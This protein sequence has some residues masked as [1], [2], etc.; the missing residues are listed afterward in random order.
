VNLTDKE[1]IQRIKTD[2]QTSFES[3]YGY[4]FAKLSYFSNQY[5][6]DREAADSLVQDVFA[7]LWE[8]RKKL[9]DDT[10]I[11]AWLFTVTK[12]K[13]LK[14]IS[15]EKSKQ[16][17]NN[18]ILFRQ[19]E[20]NYHSLSLFDTSHFVFEELQQ[21]LEASL[22]KLSPAVRI[23]FEKSRFEDKKNREIAEELGIS[24]KT[25]EAHISKALKALRSDL[26][27]YLPLLYLL[28]FLK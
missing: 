3:L 10:N 20:I 23:A 25:V 14:I 17:Y 7:E 24:I 22:A 5:L 1:I 26:K 13:S 4:F 9:Q 21:K 16:R 15:K 19:L 18:Y 11:H 8:N 12:N 2:D 28:F 6:F 27:E